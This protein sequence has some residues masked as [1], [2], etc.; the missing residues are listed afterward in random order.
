[1]LT[2]N[3][4][5]ILNEPAF[6]TE[7]PPEVFLPAAEACLS[8]LCARFPRYAEFLCQRAQRNF[9]R[10][11]NSFDDLDR[12]PAVYLPVLKS[13]RFPVPADVPIVQQL[14]SSG[15]TGQPSVTPLD[16][17]SWTR[18]VRAMRGSYQFMGLL[19][20][21]L[22][23]LA[24]L[25]DPETTKMAG[26]LV[27]DAV[28]RSVPNV[29]GIHYLARM[30]PSGPQFAIEQAV[31]VLA[32]AVRQGPVVLV[33]YPALIAAAMQGMARAGQNSLPL[34]PGS[35]ILTG[36]GWKSFLPGVGLD[37]EEFRHQASAFFGI[38]RET[39]RDMYGLSE[40]PAVFVQCEQGRYHVPAWCWAQAIDPEVGR[41]VALGE[42]G[43]LQITTPLTTSYP[44]LRILTTDRVTLGRGCP[45]G[46]VARFLT[47]CGRV[48]AARFET[49]A[50]KIGQAVA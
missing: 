34:R 14:T 35:R 4:D 30:G 15:T 10:H 32:D 16:E 42:Q 9:Q 20:G 45:C 26:S 47:P 46:R 13:F 49:C 36:G 33:G 41:E 18:R 3:L 22:T 17:P 50:M 43:L 28:L 31:A 7:T 44:L 6:A 11:F 29:R 21:E 39:I 5:A 19:E 25:M 27:I 37:Q 48:S 40:C 38:P 12:L 2:S 23:A 1:M 8:A 24:F